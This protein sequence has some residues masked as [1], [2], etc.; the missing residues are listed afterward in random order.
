MIGIQNG[1][2]RDETGRQRVKDAISILESGNIKFSEFGGDPIRQYYADVQ[3]VALRLDASI[4][5]DTWAA[6][7]TQLGGGTGGLVKNGGIWTDIIGINPNI[8]NNSPE[9]IA[10]ALLHEIYHESS[11]VDTEANLLSQKIF[12]GVTGLSAAQKITVQRFSEEVIIRDKVASVSDATGVVDG[13]NQRFTPEQVERF[14]VTYNNLYASQSGGAAGRLNDAQISSIGNIYSRSEFVD[15][16]P[17][18]VDGDASPGSA[19]ASGVSR[20]ISSVF[21]GIASFIEGTVDFIGRLFRAQPIVV[22]L[23]GDGVEITYG[24]NVSFD[25]DGD[26]YKEKTSWA[27]ADDGFLVIDLN[28]NGTRGVGDNMI[29]QGK[30]IQF[31]LWTAT[32]TNDTDLQAL[33]YFDKA[34]NGGNND[35][36]LTSADSVWRELKIWQDAN[37]DGITKDG[38]LK[39]LSSLGITRLAL[40]YDGGATLGD[41]SDDVTMFGSTLHGL[42]SYWK[43]SERFNGGLGDMSLTYDP[44]GW[45][46]VDLPTGY[47]IQFEQGGKLAVVELEGRSSP[48]IDL[49]ASALDGAIGDV[50]SNNLDASGHSRSVRISGGSGNDTIIGGENDDFISGDFGAD[51]IRGYGGN[52]HIFFDAEDLN[53]GKTV[54]GDAGVDVAHIEGSTGIT[55]N[56][57]DHTF[58]HAYGGIGADRILAIGLD[59]DV[60]IASGN[61]NDTI[62]GGAGNDNLSGDAGADNISGGSGDD[63]LSGGFGND[64]M[65]GETGTDI[66]SGGDGDDSLDGGFGDDIILGGSGSDNLYGGGDDDRID[67]GFGHD[68]LQGG[69]GDDIITA[70]SGNDIIYFWTGDDKLV[71]ESGDDLFRMRSENENVSVLGRHIVQGGKGNDTLELVGNQ[72]EW[73]HA[74]VSG[75]PNQWLFYNLNEGSI[76]VVIDVQDVETIVFSDG[77]TL[78]LSTDINIDTSDDYERQIFGV[79][80][81][82]SNWHSG[83]SSSH[84]SAGFGED[85]IDARRLHKLINL[86]WTEF[87]STDTIMGGSGEDRI[88]SGDMDDK[89]YGQSGTDQIFGQNGDDY[90]EGGSGSD[91]ISGDRG[92]DTIHGNAGSDIINGGYD[93]DLIYGDDGSD[94]IVG[95]IGR[96]T[97][98]GGT[99]SDEIDGG[100]DDDVLLG[101]SGADRLYGGFGNDRLEGEEGADILS[102]GHGDDTL[103]GG[104]GLNVLS[105]N[106]GDD[107]LVG[108]VDDDLIGGEVGNDTLNGGFGS[109]TLIGGA[110]ADVLNGGTGILDMLSYEGSNAAVTVRLEV[111]VGEETTQAASGGHATGDNL[112]GFEQ[113]VG[114]DHSDYLT[115]SAIDNVMVGGK[116]NDQIW[117]IDGHDDIS[118]GDGNDTLHGGTG[119]DRVWG[120][121]GDDVITASWGAD[122]IYGGTGLDTFDFSSS[123]GSASID[124]MTNVHTGFAS[125]T[126]I[127]QVE[128]V[129][130]GSGDDTVLGNGAV[131]TLEGGTGNDLLHGRSGDDILG[132][133]TGNDTLDGGVGADVMTGGAGNDLFWIDD[134]GDSIV[135]VVGGGIDQINTSISIDLSRTGNV[136]AN[137]ENLA[138]QGTEDINAFG[139]AANN[140]LNGNSGDNL[141]D[142]RDGDDILNGGAGN[143]TLN[144]NTGADTMI[145]G[146][147]NDL[148]WIN[149][150][151]DTVDELANGGVDQINASVSIDLNRTGE[152]Y[153]NVENIAL[154]GTSNLGAWG[155][156]SDNRLFGNAGANILDGRIGND[157]LSGGAGNDSLWGGS[158]NDMLTGGEGSDTF[159]FSRGIDQD[160]VFD[161]QDN[162]DTIRLINLE[163]SNFAQARTFATQSGTSVVFNFGD[164]D[165]LT[166]RNMTINALGDDLIFV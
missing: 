15:P 100:Y 58:E 125:E 1:V 52:D 63:R 112:A 9:K 87:M 156:T 149:D 111:T 108:G 80:D 42:G 14:L 78:R 45:R 2:V 121:A 145:G 16:A 126:L 132:G 11:V 161:F 62:V 73:Q 34:A 20:F 104:D 144:G 59:S 7:R 103:L 90:I 31:G 99:G 130:A 138:L 141:L 102:G 151:Y 166:I 164:G 113:V 105:G 101:G 72:S 25:I 75:T 133:N 61:G 71:G 43:G 56:M 22:D 140:R 64:T 57:L 165:T 131:N 129:T 5:G 107:S 60:L 88:I 26:G 53:G 94:V 4:G 109:D 98:Y 152:F 95:G 97:I 163:V 119:S 51:I 28:A 142:G 96:D 44:L 81:Y 41:K 49:D 17:S 146:A 89:A 66:V 135:E 10:A 157:I 36:Y 158:G 110:G 123:V 23:D 128:N 83:N 92:N 106:D 54:T 35:G 162:A 67:G 124:L 33:S 12:N 68:T 153:S 70:G 47:E 150:T 114:S 32:N 86:E 30:E 18:D 143:D 29:N 93:Q 160:I 148:F 127:Y 122:T 65:R 139:G 8:T 39:T 82:Y 115:G 21:D 46:H 84:I 85:H 13:D 118:G 136:Y 6:N 38:E 3:V 37:Q 91:Q 55:L 154:Q 120:D 137:V 116:G 76:G 117:G 50:R 24:T 159:V 77:K 19:G 155:N 40:G 147:G 69:S 27:A 134:A 79:G 74:R 48:N